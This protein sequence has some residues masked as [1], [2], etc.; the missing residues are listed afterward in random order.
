MAPS[1][2]LS[3]CTLVLLTARLLVADIQISQISDGQI[4]A[5]PSTTLDALEGRSTDTAVSTAPALIPITA[6]N[7]TATVAAPSSTTGS[8]LP[9]SILM[10]APAGAAG[11]ASNYTGLQTVVASSF[12][13]PHVPIPVAGTGT[14][15]LGGLNGT[16]A[17]VANGPTAISTLAPAETSV[18][19]ESPTSTSTEGPLAATGAATRLSRLPIGKEL[20][21]AGILAWFVG[22][23]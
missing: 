14:P 8:I 10:A 17:V 9:T 19:A 11:A 21:A 7:N 22:I 13:T 1:I 23:T 6:L 12:P 3:F 20:V 5:G 2:L 4:Q 18:G 16:S 15:A